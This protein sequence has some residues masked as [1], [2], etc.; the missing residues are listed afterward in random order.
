MTDAWT[1]FDRGPEGGSSLAEVEV[2]LQ[3]PL[4]G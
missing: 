3:M 1:E 2:G 4:S